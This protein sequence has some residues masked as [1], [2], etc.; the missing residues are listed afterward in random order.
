V[1]GG[2]RSIKLRGDPSGKT[3]G[4]RI[5]TGGADGYVMQWELV[6]V[7][8]TRKDGSAIR[9]VDLRCLSTAEEHAGP[10][11]FRLESP[12]APYNP[13]DPPMV[14]ALDCIM[15][16]PT[17]FIAGTHACDVWEVDKDP[18]IVVEG[19]EEDMWRFA[20][21][22]TM[23]NVFASTCLS[24]V[25]RVWDANLFDVTCSC[26]LGFPIT[27][28]AYSNEEYGCSTYG[29]PSRAGFHL[30]VGSHG[31]Y[32]L[33]DWHKVAII[34]STSLQPLRILK[35]P[36]A[37]IK[38]LKYSPAGGGMLA[39]GSDD[40]AIYVYNAKADYQLVSKCVGHSG[41]VE[42]IDWTLP[43]SLPGH[44]LHGAMI[45]KAVDQSGNLLYWDPKTGRKIAQ[46]QRNAPLATCTAKLGFEV[47]GIWAD[48]SDYTDINSLC[49][50][51]R[52]R[53]TYC[54]VPGADPAACV[55][56][57]TEAESADGVPGCG[58]LVTADDMS[59]VRLFNFPVVWDDAPYKEFHGHASHVMWTQFSCDD[60]FV[61]SAG[62]NDRGI[63]QWRT[64]GVNREDA[65]ADRMLLACLDHMITERQNGASTH[66][67]KP[68]VEWVP[69]EEG[70]RVY[71][72]KGHKDTLERTA[73]SLAATGPAST[74]QT[75][76]RTTVIKR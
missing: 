69:L 38:E 71:G 29:D 13:K 53:P 72:P 43:I 30:A 19:N 67:P 28:I 9:G 50:S 26:N 58:Y 20:V 34:D 32:A 10:N 33:G 12:A 62:G 7:T 75:L 16:K 23:P 24:G 8:G 21:H 42:H 73:A 55:C 22:P 15:S 5:V 11:R 47:M 36:N 52:G 45:F 3:T 44:K 27:G 59:S 51:A 14:V 40:M 63:Y 76:G 56:T 35:D 66:E 25:V 37:Q 54:P 6:E 49:A 61:F 68:G 1:H 70:G 57:A 39:A 48:D 18:R 31:G 74:P 64:V 17:E 65:E 41:N 60:R 4:R 2:L 46:N